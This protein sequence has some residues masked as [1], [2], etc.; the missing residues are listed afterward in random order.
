[1]SDIVSSKSPPEHGSL[2]YDTPRSNPY[3]KP[4]LDMVP[5]NSEE[6]KEP[7]YAAE[8][9]GNKEPVYA[10]PDEMN[11]FNNMAYASLTLQAEA[12]VYSTMDALQKNADAASIHTN[13]K[14]D[15]KG[16]AYQ[17]IL[18]YLIFTLLLFISTGLASAALAMVLLHPDPTQNCNCMLNVETLNMLGT[19]QNRLDE[20]SRKLER[21]RQ[22]TRKLASLVAE[23]SENTS[24]LLAPPVAPTAASLSTNVTQVLHNCTTKVETQCRVSLE[25][26]ECQTSCVPEMEPGSVATNFQCIRLESEEPNPLI[27]MIDVTGGEVLCLCYVI[28]INDNGPQRHPVDCALRATRCTLANLQV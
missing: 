2:E 14:T 8:S 18:C 19:F 10:A 1:M 9:R 6:T 23:L 26:R 3:I 13:R 28:E 12:N 21:S 11:V 24:T 20:T 5:E 27:G 17:R 15:K 22:E 7:V 25:Q 4:R 16:L